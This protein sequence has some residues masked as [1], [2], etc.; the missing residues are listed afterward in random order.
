MFLGSKAV[1]TEQEKER[2]ASARETIKRGREHFAN[3]DRVKSR[4]GENK[5]EEAVKNQLNKRRQRSEE[6]SRHNPPKKSRA[7]PEGKSTRASSSGKRKEEP[8]VSQPSS[9]PEKKLLSEVMKS[10]LTVALIDKT[11][12]LGKLSM[13]HWKTVERLLIEELYKHI[14]SDTKGLIPFFDGAGWF[15]GV[16]LIKCNDQ[17]SLDW[18]TKAVR[19]LKGLWEGAALE[20]VERSNIPSIPKAKVFIPVSMPPEVVLDLL[21]RQ[22]TTIPTS[23]WKIL[24]VV[25]A[26]DKDAGQMHILQINK[27]A[28]DILYPRFG[29]MAWGISC[30][31]LRLKRRNPNDNREHTL[32]AGE[33]EKDLENLSLTEESANPDDKSPSDQS[34]S[35]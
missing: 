7:E 2:L 31:Y 21:K 26:V 10:H 1:C 34:T 3:I 16:K 27:E 30:V 23:D 4:G 24:K 28:E 15:Q 20:I 13:S 35:Q 18:C 32:E 14:T 9:Q 22:N 12:E 11:E 29:K 25:K 17:F 8:L 6:E 33:V 5:I 19:N